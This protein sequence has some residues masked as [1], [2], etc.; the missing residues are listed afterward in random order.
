MVYSVNL[1]KYLRGMSQE[2]RL[3]RPCGVAFPTMK[4]LP[5]ESCTA[6]CSLVCYFS[7]R[8]CLKRQTCLCPDYQCNG[9]VPGRRR[10]ILSQC[11]GTGARHG[12]QGWGGAL[13][14]FWKYHNNQWV[15]LHRVAIDTMRILWFFPFLGQQLFDKVT[16]FTL[17]WLTDHFDCD[18]NVNTHLT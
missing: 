13:S 17:L 8:E 18:P 16:N 4:V 5:E 7:P 3:L 1:P 9:P 2:S 12:D 15:S 14:I 10:R 11:V 6:L